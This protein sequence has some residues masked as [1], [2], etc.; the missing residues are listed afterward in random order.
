MAR[1]NG[2]FGPAGARPP[3]R[4][5]PADDPFA[6]P[7]AQGNAHWPPAHP[8]QQGQGGYHFPPEPQT[9]YG[10][11]QQPAYDPYQN[12]PQHDPYA[13]QQPQWGQQ[14]DPRG[15]DLG[16]YMPDGGP[17]QYQSMDPPPFHQQAPQHDPYASQQ[18]YAE[19]EGEYGE[20]FEEE[21]EPGRGRR[22]MFIV[23]ALVGAIGVGGALAYT[24][25]S[26]VAPN[27]GRVPLVKAPDRDAKTR[28]A[29][30]TP[31]SGPSE[32]REQGRLGEAAAAPPDTQED[33]S[34]DPGGPRRVRTIP[35]TP[36]GGP[37]PGIQ[38]AP[39]AQAAAPPPSVP[40][41]MLENMGPR[42]AP[43]Q[44]AAPQQPPQRVTIGQ[45]PPPPPQ[46]A[47]EPPAPARRVAVAPPPAPPA[48]VS[49]AP[50]K[51]AAAPPPANT[52]AGFVAVLSS[53][54][55][56]MDALKVFA[57]LQQKYGDAL[58]GKTPDVQE[59]DLSARGLGTVYRL[60]IGP[61]GSRDAASSFCS[62]VKAAGHKDC[63]VTAY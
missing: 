17:Q 28:A 12:G 44:R 18:G 15:Y 10:Y 4:R 40:G 1:Q 29:A 59:A 49:K 46:Q 62:Q 9:N 33:R 38:I 21:E 56:R 47:E 53:Q 55:S 60:V 32:K 63:W 14:Q 3:A 2:P 61:P 51:T 36:G 19:T 25:K 24:Y 50:S 43:Q 16:N 54:K 27:G 58:S 52:G 5:H 7:P 48:V 30:V 31:S 11:Q 35:I 13:Q 37:P 8:T 6:A 42:P 20:E 26:F 34:D 41:I 39:P 45:P 57:D 22:W 23:A